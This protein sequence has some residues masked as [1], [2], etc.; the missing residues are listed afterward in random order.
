MAAVDIV[1]FFSERTMIF[2]NEAELRLHLAN[3]NHFSQME[4]ISH[5]IAY[6][7]R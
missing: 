6:L 7:G 2:A 1:F 5:A 3:S 4:T